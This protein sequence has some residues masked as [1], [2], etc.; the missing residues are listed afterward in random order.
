MLDQLLQAEVYG[1]NGARAGAFWKPD[2]H[3]MRHTG[4]GLFHGPT[5]LPL[6]VW[7]M[8]SFLDEEGP[9]P[10]YQKDSEESDQ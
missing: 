7:S 2:S 3:H 1:G 8:C 5:P 9:L 10:L 4:T 6:S